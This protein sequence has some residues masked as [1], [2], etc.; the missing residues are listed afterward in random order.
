MS[1]APQ[2]LGALGEEFVEVTL[3]HDPVAATAAGIHDYDHQLP[4]DSRAG[5]EARRAWLADFQ[6]RL[7]SVESASLDPVGRVERALLDSR[8]AA[9]A[10]EMDES[11]L[12]ARDP[13][14]PIETA[15]R[16]VQRLIA[17]PFAPLDE[18]KDAALERLMAI[19][20]YLD[21]ARATLDAVPEDLRVLAVDA[22]RYAP[23]SVDALTRGLI[24]QFPGESER[25]E[26]A[27]GRARVGLLRYQE[28]LERGLEPRAGETVAIG[29][30]ALES[31]LRREH[32][33]Y[34]GLG[35]LEQRARE[36]L[37]RTAAELVTEAARLDPTRSWREQIEAARAAM[38]EPRRLQEAYGIAIERA[39][40]VVDARRLLPIEAGRLDIVETPLFERPFVPAVSYVPPA[41][42]DFE[43]HGLVQVTGLDPGR[44]R[45]RG[46]WPEEHADALRPLVAARETF[47]GR[48]L[49][50]L[51]AHRA[52]TRLRR[53]CSDTV[54][55]EGW[56]LYAQELM[57][58]DELSES[59]LARLLWLRERRI[60]A[61]RVLTDVEIHRGDLA[62]PAAIE[63][64][65]EQAFVEYSRAVAV[66]HTIARRPVWGAS[67]LAGRDQI[68]AV[69][70]EA[71]AR[72]GERFD[73]REFH[74]ALLGAGVIPVALAR[75]ELGR[76]VAA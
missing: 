27:G 69:R 12:F 72:A 19:P 31:K 51:I 54:S 28:F 66:V 65:T 55:A 41:P 46:E 60:A 18:R 17:R 7:A 1:E 64:L 33:V 6:Q 14:R 25:I 71:Q 16:G 75:D 70:D 50:H 74:A 45:E 43:P 21:D 5:L 15:L 49:Q 53:M 26:H 57:A 48:H 76:S 52:R 22:A 59:P 67:A 62:L 39:R 11:R 73:L 61:L 58:A 68:T 32:C 13:L 10:I 8:V 24:R 34:A 23:G 44:A 38:P 36:E 20:K 47:P 9:I 56:A 4:D 37:E 29:A 30:G 63:R 42:F 35:T 40:G 3:R 2:R